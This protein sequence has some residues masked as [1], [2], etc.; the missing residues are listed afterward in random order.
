MPDQH[1]CLICLNSKFVDFRGRVLEECKNC[2]SKARDRAIALII[3][4]TNLFDKNDRDILHISPEKGLGEMLKKKY[5][6]RYHI[7]DPST[8][9][10]EEAPPLD[11]E[12]RIADLAVVGAQKYD[13]IIHNNFLETVPQNP[14]KVVENLDS[15][16]KPGGLHLFTVTIRGTR[17]DEGRDLVLTEEEKKQ[18]FGRADRHRVFGSVDFPQSIA[19]QRN[20]ISGRFPLL[21]RFPASELERWRIHPNDFKNITSNSVFY[22]IAPN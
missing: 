21:N 11:I 2:R 19:R 20:Q 8:A 18:R 15:A 3:R 1:I 5:G 14:F 12:G 9:E 10:T 6:A 7:F 4:T 16:L 22:Y 17:T 13:L